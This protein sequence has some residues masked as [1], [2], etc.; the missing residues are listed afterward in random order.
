MLFGLVAAAMASLSNWPI[1]MS[2]AALALVGAVAVWRSRK[3]VS[4]FVFDHRQPLTDFHRRRPHHVR[5]LAAALFDVPAGLAVA[6]LQQD[7]AMMVTVKQGD[8]TLCFRLPWTLRE[9]N[10]GAPEQL[11]TEPLLTTRLDWRGAVIVE[12]LRRLDTCTLTK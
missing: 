12:R 3:P 1:A 8:T 10:L 7:A 11:T 2:F 6:S 4:V 5:R 9:M